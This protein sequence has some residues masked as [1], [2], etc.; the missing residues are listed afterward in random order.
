MVVLVAAPAFRLQ[1]VDEA[2]CDEFVD[3]FLRDVAVALGPH[4][5]FAQLWRQGARPRDQILGGRNG[6]RRSGRTQLG[7]AHGISS[8][9]WPKSAPAVGADQALRPETAA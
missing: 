6:A 8:C 5:A 1:G 7:D 2:G 4:R 9:C 3:G